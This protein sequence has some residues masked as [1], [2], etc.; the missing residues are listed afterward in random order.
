M[1]EP[2]EACG[3]LVRG[4]GGWGGRAAEP[5]DSFDRCHCYMIQDSGIML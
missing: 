2:S 4:G 5:G 3:C 1:A